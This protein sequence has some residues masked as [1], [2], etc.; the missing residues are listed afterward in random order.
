[1][2]MEFEEAFQLSVVKWEKFKLSNIPGD[3]GG[4][5]FAGITKK[6]FPEWPGWKLLL[7][8]GGVEAAT[9]KKFVQDFY[10]D[11]WNKLRCDEMPGPIARVV[12]DTR[13]LQGPHPAGYVLQRGMN[14]ANNKEEFWDDL[15]ED[16]WVGDKTIAAVKQVDGYLTQRV[17]QAMVLAR[18]A[19]IYDLIAE[20]PE[21][22]KFFGWVPRVLDPDFLF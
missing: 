15:V 5:T 1:M 4:E 3:T 14:I 19:M 7:G 8:K 13:I 11:M 2:S 20:R 22:E 12:F 6:W 16:G 17:V 10:Q 21:N 9:I 18:A